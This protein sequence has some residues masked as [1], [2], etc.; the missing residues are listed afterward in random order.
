MSGGVVFIVHDSYGTLSITTRRGTHGWWKE[1]DWH[2][3]GHDVAH[4]EGSHNDAGRRLQ[5][6]A[7][8]AD[9]KCGEDSDA[10]CEGERCEDD[11]DRNTGSRVDSDK[12][13]GRGDKDSKVGDYTRESSGEVDG[14]Q[15]ADC[16]QDDGN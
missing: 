3:K 10:R 4:N 11:K 14:S 7:G 13:E 9:G 8:R 15:D 12:G 16:A 6:E 1:S 2:P 5:Q